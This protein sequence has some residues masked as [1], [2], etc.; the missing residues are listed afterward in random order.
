MGLFSDAA[1]MGIG[2]TIN[3]PKIVF[4]FQYFG[5]NLIFQKS[6]Y[7]LIVLSMLSMSMIFETSAKFRGTF[8]VLV[9]VKA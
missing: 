1:E 2:V 9:A 4:P 8:F 3:Q 5:G 7:G 6:I